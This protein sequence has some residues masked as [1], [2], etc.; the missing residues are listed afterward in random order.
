[1]KKNFLGFSLFGFFL[2]FLTIAG[3][4]SCTVMVFQAVN[5]A[6]NGNLTAIVFAVLG[7]ILLGTVICVGLDMI[8]RKI[9]V[10]SPTLKILNAT[11]EIAKGNFNVKLD[12]KHKH[13][14]FDEY[15]MIMD[16][17][18]KMTEELS[19]NELLK[20]D[21]ISNFSHE[22]KTPLSIIQNYSTILQNKSLTSDERDKYLQE[23]SKVTKRLSDLISNIL[24]LNKLEN[25]TLNPNMGKFNLAEELRLC[26]ISFENLI[27]DKR[28]TLDADIDEI[29]IFSSKE[30]LSIVWNNI[31][32]NAIK[33]TPTGG[34]IKV[35]L[36]NTGNY[37]M[38]TIRDNGCGMTKE[39]GAHIFDKF[40]QG[41]TSHS[42]E[43]NGLGLALV[44]QVI[45]ILGGE[46]TVESE[47]EKGS[48]FIVKLKKEQ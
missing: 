21:F 31:I 43:G 18:N 48:T 9:M 44:K 17:I 12:I 35:S 29:E 5:K 27:E 11:S 7:N 10:D 45:D 38:V 30:L 16:N 15:D 14:K 23:L 47:P 41:D 37:V 36:K 13:K 24:K 20:S 32:S 3:T 1:M 33:F 2:F 46:I 8:R 26:L 4:S 39:V 28:I 19:K 40:Y 22:I 42:G 6:S 25:Q 34:N